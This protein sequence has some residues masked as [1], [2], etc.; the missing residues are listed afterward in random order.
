MY[1]ARL[2][3]VA[4]GIAVDTQSNNVTAFS[5]LEELAA[6][7]FPMG[8]PAIAYLAVVERG[9][10]DDP[11]PAATLHLLLDDDEMMMQAVPLRFGGGR[12]T[13]LVVRFPAFLVPGAGALRFSLRVD[14]VEIAAYGIVARLQPATTTPPSLLS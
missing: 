11:S 14:G 5:I 10:H 1:R 12:R 13:R 3:L 6:E 9:E 4:E 8:V 2:S 7:G